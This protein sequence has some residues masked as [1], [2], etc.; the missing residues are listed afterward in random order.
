MPARDGT[1]PRGEGSKTGRGEGNCAENDKPRF[2]GYAPNRGFGRSLG[3]RRGGRRRW[4]RFR[5]AG[6]RRRAWLSQRSNDK[7]EN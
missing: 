1:G 3:L 6:M 7:T 5:N 4:F 2:T